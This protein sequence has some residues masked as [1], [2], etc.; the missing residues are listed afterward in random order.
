MA[1]F[2]LKLTGLP[3]GPWGRIYTI[4]DTSTNRI[5]ASARAAYGQVLVDPAVLTGPRRD[6]TDKETTYKMLDGFIDGWLNNAFMTTKDIAAK[7]AVTGIAKDTA[8]PA[9]DNI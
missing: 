5:L 7:A 3:G 4:P 2:R 6:M 9:D 1:A 8:T